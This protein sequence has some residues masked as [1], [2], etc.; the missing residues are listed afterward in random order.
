M[1]ASG[2]IP[3]M[4]DTDEGDSNGTPPDA[5]FLEPR[6]QRIKIKIISTTVVPPTELPTAAPILARD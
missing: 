4:A 3:A 6:R 2:W 5:V 1:P